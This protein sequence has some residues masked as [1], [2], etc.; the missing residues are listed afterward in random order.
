MS[1]TAP[2]RTT[3]LLNNFLGNDFN[4]PNDVY[5]L[6][7]GAIYFTDNPVGYPQGIRPAMTMPGAVWR[8]MPGTNDLRMMMEDFTY[9]NGITF[10][11]DEKTA[12]ISSTT[13]MYGLDKSQTIYAFDVVN[14]T[15]DW[16]DAGRGPYLA[17]KRP[18]AMSG[19]S[20]QDGIKCDR[21]GNVYV[22]DGNGVSVYSVAG[23][24]IGRVL[25]EGGAANF[26]L[27]EKEMFVLNEKK[28]WRV[29]LGDGVVGDSV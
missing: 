13:A 16:E 22:G 7:N 28:V 18:F 2:H 3:V 15:S 26:V 6:S 9:P 29:A 11:P 14:E 24:L 1:G 23:A 20:I 21:W 12:Y 19:K 4:S 5:V 10:S 17:N 25:I 27:G 8:Y